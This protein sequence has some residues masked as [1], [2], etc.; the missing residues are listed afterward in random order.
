MGDPRITRRVTLKPEAEAALDRVTTR[1]AV[2]TLD[3]REP[4]DTPGPQTAE[5]SCSPGGKAPSTVTFCCAMV[6]FTCTC[7]AVCVYVGAKVGETVG[8]AVGEAVGA[9][10]GKPQMYVGCSEGDADGTL[11]VLAVGGM[12][13]APGL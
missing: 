6:V 4:E 11:V 5:P 9:G 1:A 3:T 7:T 8:A 13:G 2:R 10:V 12:V